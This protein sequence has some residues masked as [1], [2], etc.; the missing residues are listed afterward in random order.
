VSCDRLRALT[1]AGRPVPTG[2]AR[3][4]LPAWGVATA[5]ATPFLIV[6]AVL[7]GL[8][9][10]LPIFHSSDERIYQLPTI[11][12]FSRQ[13]PFPDLAA[14][15]AAQTPLFH[16]VMAYVGRATGYQ[17]WRL[18]LIEALISYGLALAVYALLRRRMRLPQLT[19][20]VLALLFVLSPYVFGTSFRVMTDNLAAL[21]IVVALERLL[22]FGET[23]SL[24]IFAVAAAAVGAAILTRQSAA[25]MVGVALLC[26]WPLA[27]AREA[28][29]VTLALGALALACAPAAAL[30]LTWHGLVPPGG[31]TRSCGLCSGH[32]GA[33]LVIATP[34]LALAT[35]GLYGTVLLAPE[36]WRTRRV[37]RLREPLLGGLAGAVLLLVLP[38]HPGGD[39]AGF[40]WGVARHLPTVLGSSLAFWALVPL[41]G[42]VL[43]WRLPRSPRPGTV[44]AFAACF[45][46]GALAIRYP[47]QKYVDPF[48]LLVVLLTIRP[49][50]LRGRWA[51]GG[52]LV[53]ALAFVAYTADT[54]SHANANGTPSGVAQNLSVCVRNCARTGEAHAGRLLGLVGPE[55]RPVM[56]PG[57]SR[58]SRSPRPPSTS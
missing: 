53:L 52:A 56:R 41:A 15:H 36:L 22:R 46:L 4:L 40:I 13:L 17:L 49:G 23:R 48:A 19:A 18:R 28:G 42:A 54:G 1:G 10:T 2:G 7:R 24:G 3:A 51:L 43:A 44:L 33:G 11:L 8:T 14:Y 32:G 6:I 39:A 34:E 47:W 25:F 20:L 21:F 37:L 27:R 35:S 5:L 29:K 30:F 38:A 45:L 31:D 9:V 12:R 26:L 58:P 57:V 55:S 16:L 50:E